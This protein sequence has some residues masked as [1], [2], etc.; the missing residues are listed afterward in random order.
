MGKKTK[1]RKVVGFKIP[2]KVRQLAELSWKQFKKE[3]K[4][5]FD[6]KKDLKN[7]YYETI[8]ESLPD[9][10]TL[11]VRYGHVKEVVEIK[12]ELFEKL[13]DENTLALIKEQV[14]EKEADPTFKL[15]PII[16]N[17]IVQ[18]AKAQEREDNQEYDVSDV[19]DVTQTILKKKIKKLKAEGIDPDVAYDI[20]CII[21]H[22][23]VLEDKQINYRMRILMNVLYTHAQTK[24]IDFKRIIS[25]LIPK[26]YLS[27]VIIF[28][29]L[30]RKEKFAN[31]N[32]SQ[33]K[34]FISINEWIF[35]IMENKLDDSDI[36][37]IL[38]NYLSVRKRDLDAGRDSERR[39]LLKS[40]PEVEYPRCAHIIQHFI[41]SDD[42]A[43]KFF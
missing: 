8:L 18:R 29:L 9:M 17:E 25:V 32:E 31:F 35:D 27:F 11:L 20:L 21:P 5:C 26:K 7:A 13:L 28:C 23:C 41:E 34:L 10:I 6:R 24:E 16:F 42:N 38:K 2:K 33:Q 19:I 1:E 43:E 15:L 14:E 30:E 4:D 36:E 39:Y 3:N 37:M 12:D 22:E 40:L